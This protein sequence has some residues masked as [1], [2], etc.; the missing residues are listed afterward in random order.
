M[1]HTLASETCPNNKAAKAILCFYL[2]FDFYMYQTPDT[3]T[4]SG[5]GQGR[6]ECLAI[7]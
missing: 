1:A 7:S 3:E 2:V 6:L 5:G 4:R